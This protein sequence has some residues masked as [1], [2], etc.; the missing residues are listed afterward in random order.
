MTHPGPLAG[1]GGGCHHDEHV[2]ERLQVPVPPQQPPQLA[3]YQL[4][5]L[6]VQPVLGPGG[7]EPLLVLPIGGLGGVSIDS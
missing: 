3:H 1:G 4:E 2:V 5:L 6:L 7:G